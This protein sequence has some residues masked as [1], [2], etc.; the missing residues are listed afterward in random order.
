MSLIAKLRA[1]EAARKLAEANGESFVSHDAPATA[2]DAAEF[3][4]APVAPVTDQEQPYSPRLSPAR[5]HR[6]TVMASLA[7]RAIGPIWTDGDFVPPQVDNDAPSS[8][9][10]AHIRLQLIDHQRSLKATMSV[11]AKEA[12]KQEFLPLYEGWINGVLAAN[13]GLN[14]EVLT[15]IMI[16][17]MDVGD[18]VGAMPIIEYVLKHSL[19]LPDRFKST[20]P[21][22]IVDTIADAALKAF[23]LGDEAAAA[24]P[25]GILGHL[26][27][28][29][30]G[31]DMHDECRAKLQKAIGKAILL[32]GDEAD[33]RSRAGEALKRYLK[34]L[35]LDDKVGLKKDIDSL[36]RELK[37]S[38]PGD[39]R[40]AD[41][42]PSDETTAEA[43]P[44]EQS[45]PEPAEQN[46]S[47]TPSD[48]G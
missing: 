35:D 46:T 41:Q 13:S 31:I 17:R 3:T 21:V 6:Q 33:R 30:D 22:F 38:E 11:K 40:S 18:Y 10:E 27:D 12:M 19:Q 47:D 24:F 44:A 28:L 37:R 25:S 39:E 1:Q 4:D 43:P 15:T 23:A 8:T 2:A 7:G 5:R 9:E 26:E 34:A 14:D 20:A 48:D 32:G 29:I 16:W 42:A 45:A 36:Q